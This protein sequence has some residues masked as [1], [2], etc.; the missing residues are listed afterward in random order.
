MPHQVAN[1]QEASTF[2]ANQPTLKTVDLLLPDQHGVLRGKR[3]TAAELLKVYEQ[4]IFLPGSVFALDVNGNTIESTGI[5]FA[6]GDCDQP[7]KALPNSLVSVP[8]QGS[9]HAQCLLTMEQSIN[10]PYFANPRHRLDA[11][12]DRLL[13]LGYTPMVAVELEFYIT[14]SKRTRTGQLQ[15]PISPI[16]GQR[17]TNT[18]VYS[19]DNLDHYQDFLDAIMAAAHAQHL[20]V[21]T[22]VAEYAPGQFEINLHHT[23]NPLSACDQAIMLKRLIRSVASQHG[24]AATFMAKPFAQQA[25]SGMHIHLSLLD[26]QG[27]NVFAEGG[28]VSNPYLKKVLAGFEHTLADVMGLLCPKVNSLRR[29]QPDFFVPMAPTWGIDNRTVAFRIPNSDANNRRIEHRVA[30]ADANPYLVMASLLG[31]CH[32]GLTNDL[33]LS[34]Q[35][36]GNAATKVAPSLPLHWQDAQTKLINS[37]FAKDYLGD[38]Y[39]HVYCEVQKAEFNQFNQQV[40]HLEIDWYQHTL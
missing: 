20:P 14:D 33:T 11:I 8:W 24:F 4:G 10:T 7:C 15:P 34:K 38:D 27:H 13:N 2:L 22:T 19:L 17:E 21:S 29:F 26:N 1:P 39:L 35:I 31:A 30:G 6:T 36:T 23:A 16:N 37:A 3:V 32:Y 12:L 5:G 40:T 9:Q 18:Q 28:I 25:G